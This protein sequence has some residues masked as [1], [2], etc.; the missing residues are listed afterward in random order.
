MPRATG[1][2][3]KTLLVNTET[4]LTQ[5]LDVQKQILAVLSKV[6]LAGGTVSG[7]SAT[8]VAPGATPEPTAPT[9]SSLAYTVPPVPVSMRRVTSYR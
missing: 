4:I 5:Q 2:F 6:G 7:T 3:D 9:P 8:S 1:G